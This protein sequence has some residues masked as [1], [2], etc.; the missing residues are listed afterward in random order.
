MTNAFGQTA[1]TVSP[2]LLVESLSAP[3]SAPSSPPP[4]TW[5]G[6]IDLFRPMAYVIQATSSWCIP[7]AALMM[8]N[9]ALGRADRSAT[10][11]EAF[12]AWAQKYDG[13]TSTVG[14]NAYGW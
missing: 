12:I 3:L 11:Q 6:K 9:L 10:I 5:S 14:T 1:N 2:A 13:L 4:A 7:A 8:T